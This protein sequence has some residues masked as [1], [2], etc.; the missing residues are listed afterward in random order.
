MGDPDHMSAFS[1]IT[2]VPAPTNEPVHEYAPGSPER[3][4]L[5]TELDDQNAAG[6]IDLPHVIAGRHAMGSGD[7]ID[8][9]QPPRHSAVLGTLTNGGHAEAAAAV[10]AAIA[11]K[12]AW[13]ATPFDE[14]AAVLL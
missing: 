7:R 10:D 9:V 14:R 5:I 2:D 6:P 13:A 8:V 1:A 11:A 4:R 12:R 3:A